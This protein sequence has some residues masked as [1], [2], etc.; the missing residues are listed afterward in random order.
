MWVFEA[1][2]WPRALLCPLPA[3]PS[4]WT[5]PCSLQPR[6]AR[7][8]CTAPSS[9]S[10][11]LCRPPTPAP[12]LLPLAT[13]GSLRQQH[14]PAPWGPRPVPPPATTPVLL[15][16]MPRLWPP[17]RP[18]G[19]APPSPGPPVCS[20][21]GALAQAV[22]A[23]VAG[24]V[25]VLASRMVP[26]VTAQL[27]RTAPQRQLWAAVGA[28]APAARPWVPLQAPTT[29]HPAPRRSPAQQPQQWQGAS[30]QA[31]GT[32]QGGPACWCHCP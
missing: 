21:V 23:A 14:Q 28:A 5:L 19:P 29:P 15:P 27:W 22:L 24:L 11:P 10:P 3:G 12:R 9:R 32:P 18:A 30:P 4:P 6:M 8:P 13:T 31:Q 16:P 20:Q 25:E 26:P 2:G 17:Q 1:W 7:S